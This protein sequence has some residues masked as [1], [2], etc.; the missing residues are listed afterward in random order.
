MAG[1]VEEI[2]G[3]IEWLDTLCLLT[4]VGCDVDR[5]F[6]ESNGDLELFDLINKVK[7][8]IISRSFSSSR[9]KNSLLCSRMLTI[10][11]CSCFSFVVSV[12]SANCATTLFIRSQIGRGFLPIFN[13]FY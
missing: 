1:L 12:V 2:V 7:L 8:T 3:E 5:V 9:D 4:Q 6:L 10:S 11:P 13:N